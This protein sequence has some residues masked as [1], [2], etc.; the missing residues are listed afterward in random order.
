MTAGYANR[1]S[2]CLGTRYNPGLCWQTP[3]CQILVRDGEPPKLG[4]KGPISL[5]TAAG[6]FLEN[7]IQ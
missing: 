7:L 2:P 5:V 3:V 6:I 1:A 4:F